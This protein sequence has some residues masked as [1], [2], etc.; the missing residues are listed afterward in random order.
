[1]SEE[2]FD[3]IVRLIMCHFIGDY[4]LQSDYLGL[5]KG[6]DWYIMLA[7][8]ILYSVPFYFICGFTIY[9]FLFLVATH[10]IIDSIKARYKLITISQ[11]QIL[12]FIVLACMTVY[13]RGL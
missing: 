13:I 7:H 8:C 12:H 10:L 1:M 11:D 6:K 3:Y 5:N 4:F 2:L 9:Q